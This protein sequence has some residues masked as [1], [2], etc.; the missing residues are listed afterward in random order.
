MTMTIETQDLTRQG[1]GDEHAPHGTKRLFRPCVSHDTTGA[2]DT[3]QLGAYD[4]HGHSPL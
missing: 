2:Y 1:G 3:R 4:T